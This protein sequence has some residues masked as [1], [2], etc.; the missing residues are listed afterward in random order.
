M[1]PN[2]L[3]GHYLER[4]ALN[5]GMLVDALHIAVATLVG[6]DVL[7][8]WNFKHIVNVSRIQAFNVVNQEMGHGTPEIRTPWAMVYG[9]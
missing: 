5:P 3:P 2:S 9:A 7:V 1:R 6:V 8:S 4:G